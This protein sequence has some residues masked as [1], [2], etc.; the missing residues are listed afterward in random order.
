[1]MAYS[2]NGTRLLPNVTTEFEDP[3][4]SPWGR[5]HTQG[6]VQTNYEP[7]S[8][9]PPALVLTVSKPTDLRVPLSSTY[10]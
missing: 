10:V 6:L 5:W 3:T 8:R 2:N 7:Q 4:A 1:M 9:S